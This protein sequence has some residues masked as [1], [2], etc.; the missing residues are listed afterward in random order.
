MAKRRKK[1]I[2]RAVR[3]KKKG[4]SGFSI[5]MIIILCFSFSLVL[6]SGFEVNGSYSYNTRRAKNVIMQKTSKIERWAGG[7]WGVGVILKQIF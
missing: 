1:I 4:L 7:L 2:V 3:K 6:L 5:F